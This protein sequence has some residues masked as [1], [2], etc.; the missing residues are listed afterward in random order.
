VRAVNRFS[1]TVGATTLTLR[2]PERSAVVT[3]TFPTSDR[4]VTVE[5][6]ECVEVDGG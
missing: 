2:A 6:T 1:E 4:A 5:V 3:R